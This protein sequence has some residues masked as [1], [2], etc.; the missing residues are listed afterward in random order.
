[1]R[2]P[3]LKAK[4]DGFYLGKTRLKL[5]GNHTWNTVQPFNGKT[6]PLDSLTGNFTRLWTVETRGMVLQNSFYGSNSSG[7]V[8]VGLVP[9]KNDGS[10]NKKYYKQLEKVVSKADTLDII[11]GIVFFDNAFTSYFPQGWENHPFKNLGVSDPSLVHTKGP[12]NKYQRAHV[13]KTIQTLQDYDN[14]IFEIGNE[15]HRNSVPWF[16][17]KAVKW[18]KKFTD[19]PVGVSYAS[20]VKPSAGRTQ[21]WIARTNADWAAPAGGQR[22]PNFKGHYVF[23]TD[24]ASALT[25]NVAGLRSAWNR[26]DSLWLMDGLSGDIL[27]NRSTLQPDRNYLN[28]VLAS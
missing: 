8:K 6:T 5:A 13:K 23:D 9:W 28:S 21:D 24:H 18:A 16:Q 15:L 10:L 2:T 26:Q 4:K 1:M 3:T 11:T 22:I 12:W 19:K 27:R 25:S 7:L 17:N 20:R 14:V